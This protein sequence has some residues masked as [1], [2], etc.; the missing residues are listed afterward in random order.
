MTASEILHCQNEI[1][2]TL[3]NAIQRRWRF[4]AVNIEIDVIEGEQTENCI[5]LSYTRHLW[6]LLRH[7]E[8]LPYQC[9]D[10]FSRLRI[11]MTAEQARPW[12][13]STLVLD[14]DGNYRFAFQYG[15]PSRLNGIHDDGSMLV[16][17]NPKAFLRASSAN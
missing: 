14:T 11:L 12:S 10:Q 16:D 13:S 15:T 7:S 3:A 2:T 17:F 1:V 4:V 9:Y 5:T 8:K 6:K